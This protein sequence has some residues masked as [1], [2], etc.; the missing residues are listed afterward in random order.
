[1]CVILDDLISCSI[2]EITFGVFSFPYIYYTPFKTYPS[3][4]LQNYHH[5][6]TVEVIPLVNVLDRD[7]TPKNYVCQI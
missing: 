1:M 6:G 7:Y 5:F 2:Y 4:N 3:L